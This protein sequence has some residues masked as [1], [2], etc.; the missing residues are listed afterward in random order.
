MSGIRILFYSL[1]NP[2]GV[3]PNQVFAGKNKSPYLLNLKTTAPPLPKYHCKT[4]KT[5]QR[6]GLKFLNLCGL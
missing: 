6:L 4:N 1:K 2:D 3:N 5:I